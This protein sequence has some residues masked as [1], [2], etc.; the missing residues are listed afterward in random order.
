MS[1][2]VQIQTEKKVI[3]KKARVILVIIDLMC[4][5]NLK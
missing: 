2:E 5:Q 3:R 1:S 4:S